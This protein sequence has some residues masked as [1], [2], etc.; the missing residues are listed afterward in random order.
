MRSTAAAAIL[1]L[2]A[3]ATVPPAHDVVIRNAMVYDGSGAA[4]ARGGVV[5]DDDRI[6]AVGDIGSA[7]GAIDID[8]GGKAVAPGF[9]NMLSWATESLIADGRSESDI[10]QGVTLE[11]FG[12]GWSMGPLNEKMKKDMVEQQGDIKF[13][14][15]WTTLAEYL[16]HLVNRGISPNIASFVGATTVR[17]HV[18]GEADRAP[19]ATELEE[20]KALVR[21]A[22]DEGALGVGS[23]LIYAPAFYAK[24]D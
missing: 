18:L 4:P 20:M 8:A 3:C 14:V 12:E 16:D 21:K 7:R 23:S 1:L 11:V 9:I 15:T 19:T 17:I 13:D 5:I 6:V 22:M 2:S 10:R 24:T